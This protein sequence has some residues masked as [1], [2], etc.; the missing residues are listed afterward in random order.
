M[1]SIENNKEN[2]LILNEIYDI[3]AELQAQNKKITQESKE[4]KKQI[5]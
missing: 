3:P 5:K 1:Q 2:H 4:M